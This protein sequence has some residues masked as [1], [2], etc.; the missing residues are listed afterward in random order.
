MS[1]SDARMTVA[2]VTC[3][4]FVNIVVMTRS[5][6][7]W[8]RKLHRWGALLICIPLLLVVISGLLLQVKKQ[9]AWV[10]PPTQSA[11]HS[12]LIVS[13]DQIL[14]TARS[15]EEAQIETWSDVDRLDVRPGRGLIKLRS[16][17]RWEVQI[18]SASGEVLASAYRRSDLIESLHDGSFFGDYAKLGIFLPAGILLLGLWLT[19]VWLWYLP[20]KVKAAKRKKR[21]LQENANTG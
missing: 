11:G 14:D 6:N 9:W 7:F 21:R 16:K 12:D 20:I 19:G 4:T 13:W 18:D 10:Q 2:V 5:F 15:I 17:N 8:S 1:S 3:L